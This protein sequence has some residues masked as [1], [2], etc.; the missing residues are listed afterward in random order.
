[1]SWNYRVVRREF[2]NGSVMWGI[3]EV[4]Y[5]YNGEA[6][7]CTDD[8]VRIEEFSLN[9]LGATVK[10]LRRALREP[11]LEYADFEAMEAAP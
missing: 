3:H 8:P 4:Y 5:D 9:D 2:P 10:R 6:D 11:V 7:S 1:M